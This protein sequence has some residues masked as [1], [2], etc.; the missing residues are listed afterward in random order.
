MGRKG[1]RDRFREWQRNIDNIVSFMFFD[2][3]DFLSSIL[4]S[5]FSYRYLVFSYSQKQLLVN[6]FGILEHSF[7]L[8]T[9][10]TD[11][12]PLITWLQY[13]SQRWI[14]LT[15]LLQWAEFKKPQGEMEYVA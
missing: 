3:K 13:V 8:V 1:V 9:L 15:N 12:C 11:F 10:L 6:R 7:I 5:E 4:W 2:R 14:E